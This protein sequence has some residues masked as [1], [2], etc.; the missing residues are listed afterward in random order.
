MRFREVPQGEARRVRQRRRQALLAEV[1][2]E[3]YQEL[4]HG[5]VRPVQ[6]R[7]RLERQVLALLERYRGVPRV[8]VRP[9]R[10]PHRRELQ[11]VALLGWLVRQ[12]AQLVWVLL[13]LERYLQARRGA[14]C[15]VAQRLRVWW[16]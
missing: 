3:R 2:L 11:G 8:E 5:E 7:L 6:R 10:R 12:R 15:L 4:P 16:V 14:V 9:E 1:R 13:G